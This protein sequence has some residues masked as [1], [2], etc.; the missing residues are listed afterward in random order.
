MNYVLQHH[1]G[2]GVLLDMTPEIAADIVA[3]L[4]APARGSLTPPPELEDAP[5]SM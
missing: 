1:D 4:S 5:S 3:P 2:P